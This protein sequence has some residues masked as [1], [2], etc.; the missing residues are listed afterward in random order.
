MVGHL[1]SP[2][3]LHIACWGGKGALMGCTR[4]TTG[5]TGTL[6]LPTADQTHTHTPPAPNLFPVLL[7]RSESI[8]TSHRRERGQGSSISCSEEKKTG[9]CA[10]HLF[11]SSFF[12]R[13]R[14]F[15]HSSLSD[16]TW[17][18]CHSY[19]GVLNQYTYAESHILT[20]RTN[21]ATHEPSKT[22]NN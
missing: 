9:D 11:S 5:P 8:L 6:P 20:P 10:A 17:T 16:P 4:R 13:P 2:K 22:N 14:C 12:R 1:A 3:L 7:S 15:P 19:Q 21:S 18:P